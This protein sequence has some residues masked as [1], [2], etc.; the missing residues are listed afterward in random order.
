MQLIRREMWGYAVLLVVLFAIAALAAREAINYVSE[1]VSG[2]PYQ[3]ITVLIWALSL[4]FMLI[5]GAFGLWAIRFSAVAEGKRR[6]GRLVDAMD[7]ISDG[8]IAVD[9]RGGITGANPAVNSLA[10]Q[11]VMQ[12]QNLAELFPGLTR[13][14]IQALVNSKEANEVEQDQ[15]LP[16]GTRT[17]RFRSQPSEGLTLL[18]IS[19]IT[20]KHAQVLHSRQ[21]A[22]LQLTGQ[23]ARGVANDFN[24]LL[25]GISGYASLLTRMKP[26]TPDGDKAISSILQS[27]ERGIALASHL[28]ELANVNRTTHP[29]DAIGEHIE[30]SLETLRNGLM[31]DWQINTRIAE[32]LAPTALT[33]IQI[34]Q[35]V[36]NLALLVADSSSAP[37]TLCIDA[38]RPSA[39]DASFSGVISI[40]SGTIRL[41]AGSEAGA[42]EIPSREAGVIYS[43]IRSIVE[44]S[45]GRLDCLSSADGS[46]AFRLLLPPGII[47]ISDTDAAGLSN[48]LKAYIATWSVMLAMPGKEQVLLEKSMID[49][50]MKVRRVSNITSVLAMSGENLDVLILHKHLLGAEARP[51]LNAIVKLNP[52]TAVAVL[53][54]DPQTDS[55]GLTSDIVFLETRASQTKILAGIIEARNLSMRR[56]HT[57]GTTGKYTA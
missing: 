29:T 26:G 31:S 14:D 50:G 28:A 47:V 5:A 2:E 15:R 49:I 52:A 11:A 7:Y 23:L 10:G 42:S 38:E 19:D 16:S 37:A 13:E 43:V 32:D 36:T 41:P 20:A 27:A 17:L 54:E 56:V 25:C 53:S 45:G 4:G 30:T 35:I 44:E 1:H 9:A 3:V 6:I 34:E 57:S 51:L 22:R 8:L 18:I 48:E 12:G 24:K 21:M 46:K 33:G 39:G 55:E 40:Y